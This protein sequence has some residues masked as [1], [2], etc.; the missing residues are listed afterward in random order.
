[1]S[2]FKNNKMKKVI[3]IVLAVFLNLSFVSCSESDDFDIVNNEGSR[4]LKDITT[5]CNGNG[6]IPP[7]PPPTDD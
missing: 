1:M 3:L 5:C 2:N 7:P 4:V 6:E